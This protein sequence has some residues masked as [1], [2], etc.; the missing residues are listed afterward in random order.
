MAKMTTK[1]TAMIA[2]SMP[3]RDLCVRCAT[4]SPILLHYRAFRTVG[5]ASAFGGPRQPGKL[6]PGPWLRIVWSRTGSL[7]PHEIKSTLC[8]F[9]ALSFDIQVEGD[10][11]VRFMIV[12]KA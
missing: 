4:V 3:V 9:C 6:E 7:R 8:R 11:N 1:Y 5:H 12:V 10:I 2:M